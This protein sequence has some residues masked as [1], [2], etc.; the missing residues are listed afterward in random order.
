MSRMDE[1]KRNAAHKSLDYIEEGMILGLGTGSTVEYLLEGLAKRI[2]ADGISIQGVPTSVKTE[3]FARK[4]G[5]P[6]TSL[7]DQ[8]GVDLCIDG[9]DQVDPKFNL[10]KGGG[11]ALTREKIVAS[12]A[13]EYVIIV[14]ESK[15]V[16]SFSFPLPVEVLEYGREYVIRE[17]ETRF[18]CKPKLRTGFT[19]DNGNIILDLHD[20][21]IKD[22]VKLE[23][24]L[25]NV[26]GVVENGLF[27]SRKPEK[28]IVGGE[29]GT[30]V[31]E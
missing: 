7:N 10:I 18:D 6:L 25:N 20:L 22:P 14:D 9:A 26:P 2:K 15:M 3:E 31:L 1:L 12:A 19:T 24:E 11:G 23:Q 21:A 28:V 8:S 5:I 29:K 27:A 13:K 4:L 16:E 17:I 30:E